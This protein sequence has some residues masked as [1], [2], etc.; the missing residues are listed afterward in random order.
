MYDLVTRLQDELNAL[1]ARQA[2]SSSSN[3][4]RGL[5]SSVAIPAATDPQAS[6]QVYPTGINPNVNLS[7]V[8][9]GSTGY[10]FTNSGGVATMAVNNAA[11]VR[12]GIGAAAAG[13]PGAHTMTIPKLTGLGANGSIT[14]NADGVV[15]A[16]VD[17]T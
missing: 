15:T 10:Q 12:G 17:P 11:T 4:S 1:K 2:A 6:A 3:S 16:Y 13:T 7:S 14:W 9:G 8:A 5:E